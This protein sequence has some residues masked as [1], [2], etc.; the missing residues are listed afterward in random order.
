MAHLETMVSAHTGPPVHVSLVCAQGDIPLPFLR[1]ADPVNGKQSTTVSESGAVFSD[2]SSVT[3]SVLFP[4]RTPIISSSLL[5]P[6]EHPS[7]VTPSTTG[8]EQADAF[9]AIRQGISILP[10]STT[11]LLRVPNSGDHT[12]VETL[13]I[14]LLFAY[15]SA[16]ST[17]KKT[18]HEVHADIT[19]SWYDL[20]ILTRERWQFKQQG[21]LPFHLAALELMSNVLAPNVLTPDAKDIDFLGR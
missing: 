14:H 19:R 3:Y 2:V 6:W 7:I 15:K 16:K 20:A 8:D 18:T 5:Y 13:Y 9:P 12:N 10:L 17:L 11:A 4:H 21:E 1:P